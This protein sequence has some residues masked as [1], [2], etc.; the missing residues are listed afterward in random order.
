V[1]HAP[2]RT[3]WPLADNLPTGERAAVPDP[4]NWNRPRTVGATQLDTVYGDLGA[5]REDGGGLLLRATLADTDRPGRLEVW[6][7]NDFR[8]MVLFTPPHRHAICIEPYTCVTDAVNLQAGGV[9]AGWR[10]L[11]PGGQWAGAVE[12]RWDPAE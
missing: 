7:T 12:W 5:I 9:D 2:A 11:P 6:T 4:L 8:E 10:E 3:V 1:L